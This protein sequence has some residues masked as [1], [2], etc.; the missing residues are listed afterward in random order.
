[1]ITTEGRTVVWLR[2]NYY[3]LTSASTFY[4]EQ[5]ICLNV[6]GSLAHPKC[7]IQIKI[8]AYDA[9]SWVEAMEWTQNGWQRIFCYPAGINLHLT[10]EVATKNGAFD[11]LIYWN[12]PLEKIVPACSDAVSGVVEELQDWYAKPDFS[13]A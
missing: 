7:R 4:Y 13:V 8:N 3:K 6:Y 2:T 1:M 10:D 12:A 9:Q 5:D 11:K